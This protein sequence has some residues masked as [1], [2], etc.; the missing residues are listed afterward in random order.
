[1]EQGKLIEGEITKD[2]IQDGEIVMTSNSAEGC[3]LG[4][5]SLSPPQP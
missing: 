4:R 1:M 2:E 3:V 5:I